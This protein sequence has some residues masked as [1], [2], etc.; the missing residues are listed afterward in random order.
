MDD[1]PWDQH[2]VVKIEG[3]M[4]SQNLLPEQIDGILLAEPIA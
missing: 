1:Q 2:M 4:S 3:P